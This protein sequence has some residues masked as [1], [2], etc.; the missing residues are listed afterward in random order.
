MIGSDLCYF[1]P[2][3]HLIEN[4]QKQRLKIS[5]FDACNDVFELANFRIP[6][7]QKLKER[8]KQRRAQRDWVEKQNKC[9]GLICFSRHHYSPLMWAHY[10]DRNKGACLVFSVKTE[11]DFAKFLPVKYTKERA[12]RNFKKKLPDLSIQ[13]LDEQ[14]LVELCAT[15]ELDWSYEEEVRLLVKLNKTEES[16]RNQFLSWNGVLELKKVFLGNNPDICAPAIKRE[17]ESIG[18]SKI[19]VVQK[20]PAFS[21]FRIVE[22]QN[23]KLWKNCT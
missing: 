7:H 5:R 23:Q 4:I 22:Q 9:F 21:G 6:Q 3:R 11:P 13:N 8:Q 16:N 17:L 14:K 12:I 15:K 20:R 2:S 19:A 18:K 1:M 10:A